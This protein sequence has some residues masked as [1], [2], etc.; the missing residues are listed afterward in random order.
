MIYAVKPQTVEEVKKPTC[1]VSQQTGSLQVYGISDWLHSLAGPE[2][3]LMSKKHTVHA[4]FVTP[5]LSIAWFL[6]F[7]VL[8]LIWSPERRPAEQSR[9]LLRW[10][11]NQPYWI[12]LS[13]RTISKT[14]REGLQSI[15]HI[16]STQASRTGE[17]T[18]DNLGMQRRHN[19][20]DSSLPV[21]N[22]LLDLR[23]AWRQGLF[24]TVW[25]VI[26]SHWTVTA[27]LNLGSPLLVRCC[28]ASA[29]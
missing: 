28:P 1:Y 19:R 18:L 29:R 23:K 8:N 24:R 3:D 25:E 26:T 20:G 17:H 10:R 6:I 15:L 5:G 27:R 7:S 22:L 13:H 9:Q 12:L 2:N 14:W 4:T 16:Y 11:W 21:I